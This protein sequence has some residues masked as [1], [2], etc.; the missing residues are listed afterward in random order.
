MAWRIGTRVW[1]IWRMVWKGLANSGLCGL[2][3][4]ETVTMSAVVVRMNLIR[5]CVVIETLSINQKRKQEPWKILHISELPRAVNS[6]DAAEPIDPNITTYTDSHSWDLLAEIP[7]RP[8][9]MQIFDRSRRSAN[10]INKVGQRAKFCWGER[11]FKSNGEALTDWAAGFW[12]RTKSV[13]MLW[14]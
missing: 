12:Q 10:S 13:E 11:W 14:H 9:V 1:K 8:A 7:D 2:T 4:L 6:S 5:Q 3:S